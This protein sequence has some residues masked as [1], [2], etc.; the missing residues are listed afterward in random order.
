MRAL[1]LLA[2][3]GRAPKVDIVAVH[4][5]NPKGKSV[6]EHA[7]DT[8]RKPSGQQGRLWLRDDLPQSLPEA[9]IFL[10]EFDSR[11]FANKHETF[12]DAGNEF[13]DCL[14]GKRRSDR[15]RPLIL[16]GHSLG[17]LLIKQALVNAHDNAHYSD[18]ESSVKG[19]VFFG[20]PHEGGNTQSAKVKLGFAAAKIAESLGFN[21]N[22]SIIQAL[23]PGSLFG[24][25][26]RES[27][28]HQLENYLI[29]SF[30]EKKSTIVTKASAT[31]G[32]P[33]HRENILGLEADHSNIC[34][35]NTNEQDDQDIYESFVEHN[36][37]WLYEEAMKDASFERRLKGLEFARHNALQPSESRSEPE[38][39]TFGSSS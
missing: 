19:L 31:F 23:T 11:I 14:R 3:G 7:W 8:W 36:F 15:C 18:I 2:E 22:D 20:T 33:G 25:F 32:L 35:F 29:I 24:D 5:L 38:F 10:Y 1:R 39:A 4:G 28:R 37:H 21:S 6:K 12:W 26:L 34:K 13:L 27:F 16:V 30:W 9:R 17:G